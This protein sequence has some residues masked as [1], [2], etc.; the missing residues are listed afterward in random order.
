MIDAEGI[1]QFRYHITKVF[2]KRVSE[3]FYENIDDTFRELYRLIDN[4][5]SSDDV[6]IMCMECWLKMCNFGGECLSICLSVCLLH[7]TM[8]WLWVKHLT[9]T[10]M[11]LIFLPKI[12]QEWDQLRSLTLPSSAESNHW[13]IVHTSKKTPECNDCLEI[14]AWPFSDTQE[15]WKYCI[16]EMA[17]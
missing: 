3:K 13:E 6:I 8:Q 4:P 11:H 17:Q 1:S 15:V 5:S 12:T 14:C 2:S 16:H 7:C 10:L 9:C